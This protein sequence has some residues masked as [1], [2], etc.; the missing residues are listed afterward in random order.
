M[1]DSLQWSRPTISTGRV[2]PAAMD[3]SSRINFYA[4]HIVKSA[5]VSVQ[6]S[7]APVVGR[8]HT[9]NPIIGELP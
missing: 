4:Q 7:P 8:S 6:Q 1:P 5:H 9:L 2:V 3:G